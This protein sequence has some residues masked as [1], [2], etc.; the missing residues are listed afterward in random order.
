M[1]RSSSRLAQ[2]MMRDDESLAVI[3]DQSPSDKSR[4]CGDYRFLRLHFKQ[5]VCLV[6][7]ATKRRADPARRRWA[8]ERGGDKK[9]GASTA[10]RLRLR[11]CHARPLPLP[12]D[13]RRWESDS[14]L[15]RMIAICRRW[16]CPSAPPCPAP[17]VRLAFCTKA[18]VSI[19][20]N[21]SPAKTRNERLALL[22]SWPVEHVLDGF[23]P[24]EFVNVKL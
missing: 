20:G 5:P 9:L 11:S 8:D 24:G 2:D 1:S 10:K 17:T 16:P 3:A 18:Y 6:A 22:L 15:V 7:R 12:R 23:R 19:P 13:A 14:T 21:G 4:F